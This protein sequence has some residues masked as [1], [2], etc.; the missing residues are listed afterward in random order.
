MI[1]AVCYTHRV[2]ANTDAPVKFYGPG[3]FGLSVAVLTARTRAEQVA[4]LTEQ[5]A[6]SNPQRLARLLSK[7]NR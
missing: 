6:V 2:M 1:A 4:A 7:L 5:Y 3:V